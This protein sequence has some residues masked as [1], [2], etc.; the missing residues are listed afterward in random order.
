MKNSTALQKLANGQYE[1]TDNLLLSPN[2]NK[3]KDSRS[4]DDLEE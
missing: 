4:I 1:V 2:N 3:V